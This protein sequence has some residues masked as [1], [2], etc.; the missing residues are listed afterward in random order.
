MHVVSEVLDIYSFALQYAFSNDEGLKHNSIVIF[1]NVL[2]IFYSLS[3][4]VVLEL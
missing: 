3:V 2:L 4:S 1:R